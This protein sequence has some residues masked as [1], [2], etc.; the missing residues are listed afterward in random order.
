MDTEIIVD[1]HIQVKAGECFMIPNKS[2]FRAF[3]V[4]LIIVLILLSAP[5]QAAR[6]VGLVRYANPTATGTGDCSSWANA[7]TAQTALTGAISGQEIW[8]TA[9]T[10]KPTILGTDRNATFLLKASVALYGGFAGTETARTQRNPAANLTIL[11]G[12][13]DDDDSQTPIITNLTTVTGNT[14]NSYHVVTGATGATLDGFSITAGYANVGGCP[15][16]T[17]GAGMYNFESNPV[18]ANVTFSGNSAQYGGGGMFNWYSNPTVTNATFS[19]NFG[20]L[21]GGGM[22]NNYS[23]PTLTNV[24]FSGNSANPMPVGWP[25]LTALQY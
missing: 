5:L 8:A 4:L 17:C 18:V 24:T 3:S 7:C 10:Y 9:G 12:D 22:E 19:G 25:A 14:T 1:R 2:F 13:I 11:S 23:N 20:G 16:E 21:N 15:G 6:A